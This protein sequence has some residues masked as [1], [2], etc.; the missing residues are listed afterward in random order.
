[1][2]LVDRRINITSNKWET[3][4]TGTVQIRNTISK[5]S[6]RLESFSVTTNDSEDMVEDVFQI[7][8]EHLKLSVKGKEKFYLLFTR[9]FSV[10]HSL[11]VYGI[12]MVDNVLTFTE[13][14]RPVTKRAGNL[15]NFGL[16][17][18]IQNMKDKDWHTL[19]VIILPS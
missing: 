12:Y 14:E 1:M 7:I 6:Y 17:N 11:N 4:F 19:E 13:N 9:S 5:E 8:E 18:L 15:S 10:E 3:H 16:E 2:S